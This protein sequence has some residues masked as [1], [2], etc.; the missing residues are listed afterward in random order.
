MKGKF[1]VIDGMD[2]TGKHTQSELLYKKFKD[3][4]DKVHLVSFPNYDNE[5]SYFVKKWLNN[6]YNY[7]DNP[8]LT[9]LFYSIDRGITYYKELKDLYDNGYTIIADRYFISN[10]LY[11][12]QNFKS[13]C[14]KMLYIQYLGIVEVEGIGLPVPD[15]T[16]ILASHPEISN[17]LIDNRYNG[18]DTKRDKNENINFQSMIYDNIGFIDNVKNIDIVKNTLGQISLIM[19]HDVEGNIFSIEDIHNKI[20]NEV[21]YI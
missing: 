14:E 10:V 15:Y 9:S 18:D 3:N 1:I 13:Y 5:S 2:G 19:I 8:Y 6:E 20:Y 11:Q 21:K 4:N 17:K 7:I 12:L 16:I